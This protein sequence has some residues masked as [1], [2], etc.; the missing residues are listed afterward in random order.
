MESHT[1][2]SHL[3]GVRIIRLPGGLERLV[4]A[5]ALWNKGSDTR[6]L[7]FKSYHQLSQR[8]PRHTISL[9]FWV[10]LYTNG[11]CSY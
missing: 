8:T 4:S 9:G 1:L 3:I 10:L 5:K 11:C 7:G 6:G 2:R